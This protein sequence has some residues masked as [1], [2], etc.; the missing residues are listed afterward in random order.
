[1]AGLVTWAK[2][3]QVVGNGPIQ[4]APPG[5]GRVVAHAPE[6]LVRF[7]H[8]RLDVQAGP[9][10]VQANEIARDV[11]KTV[12]PVS[13]VTLITRPG[14]TRGGEVRILLVERTRRVVDGQVAQDP[15]LGV[16]VLQNGP[17][18]GFN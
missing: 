9:L 6:R 13:V 1:M 15:G 12:G 4:A 18:A 7:Q 16:S 14:K 5:C 11:I 17:A 2:A 8:H 3:W 10:S